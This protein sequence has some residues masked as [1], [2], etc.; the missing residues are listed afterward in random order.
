[1]CGDE[2]YRATLNPLF[3]A[4]EDAPIEALVPPLAALGAYLVA[5]KPGVL[6]GIFDSHVA[7]PIFH[8]TLWKLNPKSLKVLRKLGSGGFGEV[9]LAEAVHAG[10]RETIVLKRAREFGQAEVWMNERVS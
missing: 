6:A 7:A 9:Y 4:G 1:M 5:A 10:K 2:L 8:Q 3:A